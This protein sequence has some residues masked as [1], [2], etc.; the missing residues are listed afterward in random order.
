MLFNVPFVADWKQIGDYRQRQTD[1]SNERE[2]KNV[3]TM[4]TKLVTKYESKK[5][6][7]SLKKSPNGSNNGMVQAW[8]EQKRLKHDILRLFTMSLFE[9]I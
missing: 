5:R 6:V 9:N 1:Y 8:V 2:N 7:Y 4:I 3:L